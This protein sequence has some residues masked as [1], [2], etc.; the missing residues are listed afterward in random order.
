M[1][2]LNFGRVMTRP[3]RPVPAALYCNWCYVPGDVKF[4][5]QGVAMSKY[6]QLFCHIERNVILSL[7]IISYFTSELALNT[8][9][10]FEVNINKAVYYNL[11][12][13]S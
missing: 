6:N 13:T 1:L 4:D 3:T 5:P 12:F 7:S 10:A 2:V 11:Y 9:W 8:F